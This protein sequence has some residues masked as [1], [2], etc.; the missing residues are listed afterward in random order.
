MTT[1]ARSTENARTRSRTFLLVGVLL[2]LLLAGFVSQYASGS[3]DGLE[4]VATDHGFAETATEHDL[5][6]SPFA[7]YA[8]SEV[9]ND[10]LAAGIAGVAGVLWTLLV[11]GALFLLLRR[12]GARD[13]SAPSQ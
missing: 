9:A 4:R 5:A 12:R 11:G 1:S 2:A 3:P 13:A 10:R 7:D 8:F 6:R